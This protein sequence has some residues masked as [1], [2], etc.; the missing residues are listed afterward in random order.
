MKSMNVILYE[1]C[2]CSH[3]FNLKDF[4]VFMEK[5]NRTVNVLSFILWFEITFLLMHKSSF[6]SGG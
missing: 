4:F 1:W 2:Q 5:K 6:I 3:T